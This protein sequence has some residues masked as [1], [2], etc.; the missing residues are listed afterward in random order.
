MTG[1]IDAT[2][3]QQVGDVPR[4]QRTPESPAGVAT[5]PA[6]AD[7]LV[8]VIVLAHDLDRE[9]DRLRKAGFRVEA[10]GRHPGRGTENL[11]VP[12]SG[13]YLEILAV[14]DPVEAAASPQGRPVLAALRR[15]GPGLA[16]W[17]VEPEDIDATGARLG[18][19]V[20]H[21]R[22]V[23]PDGTLLRWRAVGVDEA[24]DAPWRCAY[25]TWDDPGHHP[26][27]SAVAHPNGAAGLGTLEVAAP[28]V[29]AA[30]HWTGDTELVDVHL[31]AADTTDSDLRLTV[32][33]R[34]GRVVFGPS[35]W[36]HVP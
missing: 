3:E 35:G 10:G 14:V 13:Q 15:R 34:D 22:R 29:E 27:S 28:D 12:L 21:R 20:E 31:V 5:L 16:R 1:H 26:G 17:S 33:V 25:M 7:R 4:T 18:L 32:L 6:V 2:H 36:H 19:A 8:Q 24:W 9:G 23:R 30:R 11:I